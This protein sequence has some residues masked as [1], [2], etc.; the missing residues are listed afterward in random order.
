M[1]AAVYLCVPCA[2]DKCDF[3][4]S[5]V[6]MVWA[7]APAPA[8]RITLSR[9]GT[10][11]FASSGETRVRLLIIMHAC[12]I[13]RLQSC[14]CISK[15]AIL[16]VQLGCMHQQGCD[17]ACLCHLQS[18]VMLQACLCARLLQSCMRAQP[19]MCTHVC[20]C[21]CCI[22]PIMHPCVRLQS[23]IMLQSCM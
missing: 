3:T 13:L 7:A 12:A 1:R 6:A 15:A 16:R 17:H 9:S 8:M 23:C 11:F 19:C 22:Q 5:N 21:G 4:A 2:A 18:C 10:T 20:V 14:M